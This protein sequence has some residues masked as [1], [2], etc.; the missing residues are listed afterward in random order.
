MKRILIVFVAFLMMAGVAMAAKEKCTTIQSG[1]LV[2]S[3]G[4]TLTTG[5]DEWGYNYQAMMFNGLYCDAYRDAAWCQDWAEDRL[6]MKW[7]AAWLSNVDCDGDGLLDR[8]YGF[9]S[10]I[11]SGAWLTNHMSGEY[12]SD[13]YN[14]Y[15]LVAKDPTTWEPI[16]GGANGE[17]IFDVDSFEFTATGLEFG[18]EY[19]LMYYP[20]PWPAAGCMILGTGTSDGLGALAISGDFNFGAIPIVGDLNAPGYKIWLVPSSDV[21]C[22]TGMVAWNPT[23][24]LFEYDIY[25][26][27]MTCYWDYFTKIVAAPA[28]AYEEGGYWYTADGVEIGPSIWGEFATIQE[29][30]NDPCAGFEGIQYNGDAPTG[31]GW[32]KPVVEVE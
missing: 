27:P 15:T 9:D 30:Y 28:D 16:V 1:E 3:Y 6:M 4:E 18:V 32:Y 2:N 19:S 20:D 31:F 13:E 26:V 21:S 14:V 5:Y 7:N 24:Y 8:H 23:R 12:P 11:G 10:Y 25:S 22:P 29:V 17:M